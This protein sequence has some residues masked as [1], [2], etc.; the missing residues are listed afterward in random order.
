MVTTIDPDAHTKL[1]LRDVR[2]LEADGAFDVAMDAGLIS[3]VGPV[4]S[5]DS[6]AADEVDA[7]GRLCTAAFVDGHV[8]LDKSYLSELPGFAGKVGAEFFDE[9]AKFKAS[10]GPEGG[11]AT[12]MDR[13]RRAAH[14]VILNG[15]GTLRAQI[16]VDPIV[17]LAHLDAALALREELAPLLR[18]Q[19]VVFPQEGL[20]GNP[21]AAEL[22]EEALHRGADVMGGAH[23]FDR[24]ATS[25]DHYEA[26]FELAARHDVD[27]DLHLDFDATPEWPLETWDIWQVA[28][29]TRERGWQGRVTVAHLTQHGQLDPAG[30]E[31]LAALLV[32][33]NIALTVVPGAELHGA[34]FWTEVPLDDVGAATAGYGELVERGVQLSY[35]GGH[36]ADAFNPFGDGD[37]L[38]DGLLLSAARNLGDPCVGGCHILTLGTTTPAAAAGLP[39]PHGIVPGALADCVVFDASDADTAVRHQA[40][41]WLVIHHG[42]PVATTRTTKELLS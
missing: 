28:R 23:G 9:L 42:R 24:S 25:T 41:R 13:M 2:L 31:A 15:T 22:V 16:D 4:G 20:V 30:R 38:R 32:D 37:L 7:E 39:G 36:L 26:C 35:A 34:R 10:T 19:I 17:G 40:D 12:V 3:A 33:N 18:L 14:N 6:H 27:I 29:L 5:L 1:I 8:H 11:P 21:A